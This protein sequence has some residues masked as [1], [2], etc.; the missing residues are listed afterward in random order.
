MKIAKKIEIYILKIIRNNISIHNFDTVNYIIKKYEFI[1]KNIIEKIQSYTCNIFK[2]MIKNDNKNYE[3]Y[4]KKIN[5]LD[6]DNYTIITNFAEK[7]SSS[8]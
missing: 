2:K 1:D 6:D 7:F 3:S 8:Y 4:L 5:Y